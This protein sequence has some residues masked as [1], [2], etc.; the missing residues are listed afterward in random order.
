[1]KLPR[2]CLGAALACLALGACHQIS[3][4]VGGGNAPS[5]QVVATVGGEEVTLRELNAELAGA[6]AA[7]PAQRKSMQD[8]ALRNLIIRKVLAHAA[9]DRGLDKSADFALLQKRA[10]EALLASTLRD[11]LVAN[12]PAPSDEEIRQFISDHPDLFSQ[13]KMFE[14]D[15]IT[16]P[17][18]PDPGLI[19]QLEPLD[20]LDAVGAV[21]TAAH[22][23]FQRRPGELDAAAMGPQV[24]D[25]I[26][27][28]PPH[29]VFIVPTDNLI[30]I[31]QIRDTKILPL[32]GDP[33]YR[34]AGDYLRRQHAEGAVSKG[35]GEIL[36]KASPAIR[37][38]PAYQPQ[39]PGPGATGTPAK[40]AALN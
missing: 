34:L 10:D 39:A 15:Q 27:K 1:M 6:T 37:Y 12:V 13:R 38:N 33:A 40:T 35:I 20:T 26:L 18:A 30:V 24:T 32:T 4:L 17:H 3:G 11:R 25:A 14:V 21:L 16:A 23:E 22:V 5:G 7:N 29:D 31:N 9:R 2:V 8:A 36:A 19:K 28:L